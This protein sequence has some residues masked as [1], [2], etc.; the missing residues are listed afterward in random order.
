M[1]NS[2]IKPIKFFLTFQNVK[3]EKSE[4]SNT[5]LVLFYYYYFKYKSKDIESDYSRI[6]YAK[7]QGF[8]SPTRLHLSTITK[9]L[10][11]SDAFSAYIYNAGFGALFFRL[12]ILTNT[13]K[14]LSILSITEKVSL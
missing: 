2:S 12:K 14:Y 13:Q 1:S 5:T 10:K 7:Y 4:Y 8:T 9:N 11:I 3:F 6:S